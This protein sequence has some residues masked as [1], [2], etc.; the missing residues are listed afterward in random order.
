[1]S[2]FASHQENRPPGSIVIP[3]NAFADEWEG[4]PADPVCA[5]L[6][7][8]SHQDLQAARAI[9]RERA[10][11]GIP[12][13]DVEDVNEVYAWSDAYNDALL[14]H[15]VAMGTCDPNDSKLAWPLISAA[16]EDIVR[17]FMTSDGI[18]LVFDA[19]EQ[20]RLASDPTQREADDE[21][22][23]ELAVLLHERCGGLERARACRV[24]RL[25]AFCLD[26]LQSVPAPTE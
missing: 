6:R 14:A 22:V 15:I 5:G 11:R 12:D 4:K 1:M 19:W 3:P 20:M 16:P 2:A 7:L 17:M 13:P 8:I 21:E 25:L 24:R 23:V 9:A 26:E 18:K 10:N